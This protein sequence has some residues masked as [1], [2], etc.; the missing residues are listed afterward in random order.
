MNN[1]KIY[2]FLSEVPLFKGILPEE[3]EIL[4]SCL[5]AERKQYEKHQW[6]FQAGELIRKVGIVLDGKVQL[7]QEDYMGNRHILAEVGKGELF[8]EAF[9]CIEEEI[10]FGIVAEESCEILFLNYEKVVSSC[11]SLCSFHGRLIKNMIGVLAMKNSYLTRKMDY[12][13]RRSTKEKLLS[14]LWEQSKSANSTEF[15]IP[16]NRQQLADYLCVERSAMSHELGKLRM[17]GKLEYR[18]NKFRF[19]NL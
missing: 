10:P 17:E 18:K 7:V 9:S 15:E 14:Y 5:G 12:V 16:F 3:I 13:T 11:S 1:T 8:A 2:G 4:L 6:I 19:L